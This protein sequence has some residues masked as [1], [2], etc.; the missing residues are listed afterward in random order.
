MKTIR[1]YTHNDTCIIWM[2]DYLK[3]HNKSSIEELTIV[4][5]TM[6]I[7]SEKDAIEQESIYIGFD[8]YDAEGNIAD[9]ER[10][11]EVLE[12][13]IADKEVM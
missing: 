5:L 7:E 6:M 8:D 9:M 11:I 12:E 13:M 3:E 10:Y 1:D 4:E 2:E